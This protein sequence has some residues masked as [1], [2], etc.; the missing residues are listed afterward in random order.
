MS[1]ECVDEKIAEKAYKIFKKVFLPTENFWEDLDRVAERVDDREKN[2]K[3]KTEM[4]MI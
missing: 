2:K 4:K 3:L 1:S